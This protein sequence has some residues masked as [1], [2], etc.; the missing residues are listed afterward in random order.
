MELAWRVNERRMVLRPATPDDAA[1]MLEVVRGIAGE[2]IYFVIEPGE[3]RTEEVQ[4]QQIAGIEPENECWIVAEVDG[5]VAGHIQVRRGA[6]AKVRH[7][8]SLGIALAPP[9]RNMGI[10]PRMMAAAEAWARQVGV[11]KLHLGVFATN[12]RARRMYERLGYQVE[13][14]QKGQFLIRGTY[15]DDVLMG[16]W[17][18]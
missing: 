9:Y 1:G 5:A 2:D 15:V 6:L 17:L 13:G 10:G 14:V 7:T 18:D 3:L 12:D 8:A 4:R 16:K 11:K